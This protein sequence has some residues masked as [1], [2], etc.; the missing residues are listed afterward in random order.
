MNKKFSMEMTFRCRHKYIIFIIP[1][2]EFLYLEFRGVDFKFKN[3]DRHALDKVLHFLCKEMTEDV[4]RK[5]MFDVLHNNYIPKNDPNYAD[6]N[7]EITYEGE[8]KF[9]NEYT[10]IQPI[11]IIWHYIEILSMV[12]NVYLLS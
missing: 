3:G 12:D 5:V 6:I 11:D 4:K 7:V 2:S 1:S 8:R 9:Y 10:H